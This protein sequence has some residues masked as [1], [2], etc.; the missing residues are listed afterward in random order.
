MFDE[1]FKTSD[2]K[3]MQPSWEKLL[4]QIHLYERDV[5]TDRPYDVT[6]LELVDVWRHI[7]YYVANTTTN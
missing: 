3:T 4:Q 1:S 5:W 7:I 6:H 2:D